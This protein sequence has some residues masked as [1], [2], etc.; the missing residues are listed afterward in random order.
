MIVE[1]YFK[2]TVQVLKKIKSWSQYILIIK[3]FTF[4]SYVYLLITIK[5]IQLNYLL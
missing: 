3:S 4:F 5:L 2:I 1:N